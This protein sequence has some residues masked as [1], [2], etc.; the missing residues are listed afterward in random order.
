MDKIRDMIY[1]ELK[2]LF[3][4]YYIDYD[5]KNFERVYASFVD[6]VIYN[7]R[8]EA[9]DDFEDVADDDIEDNVHFMVINDLLVFLRNMSE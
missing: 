3:N 8:L 5:E 1:D 2:G 9:D 7:N 4:E 6:G